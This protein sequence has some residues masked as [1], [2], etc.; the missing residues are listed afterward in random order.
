METDD[1]EDLDDDINNDNEDIDDEFFTDAEQKANPPIDL[2][3]GKPKGFYIVEQYAIPVD[4]FD[5]EIRSILDATM[6]AG[7]TAA[8][9]NG[10]PTSGVAGNNDVVDTGD[11]EDDGP[12][13]TIVGHG[14]TRDDLIRLNIDSGKNVTLPIAL[15][16]L[17]P[18]EYP[19]FSRARKACRKGYILIHEGPLEK[20]NVFDSDKCVRGRVRN[21]ILPEDVIGKQ[22]RMGG[23]FYPS[24][25]YQKPPFDL[26]VVYEDDHFAI[27]NK[28]PGVVVYSHRKGGHGTMTVRAALPFVLQPPKRGTHA[29]LRRPMACHRLDRPTAGLLLIAKT[30][31]AMVDV[32]RQF[33]SRNVKKTYMAIVNGIPDEPVETRLSTQEADGLGVDV[34]DYLDGDDSVSWQIIDYTLEEKSAVTVWRPLQYV[35]SLKARD[36]VLTLVEL[37]PKTGRYHQLRRHMA[38]VRDC[39]LVG[40]ST[41]DGGGDAMQLR[42]RGLFL[43]SN[44]VCLD[45]PYYNTKVG[46]EEWDTLPDAEKWAGGKIRLSDDGSTVEMHVSM[47]LP[48]KFDS[49][50]SREG[51]RETKFNSIEKE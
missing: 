13:T 19:S 6:V 15:M 37:K 30:K 5:A 16:L 34:L 3:E 32:T 47:D 28:P 8:A 31:P 40:D 38:W 35:K 12:E 1:E 33:V 48:D 46:R 4:G 18:V 7:G 23:G 41:Y 39:P 22:V 17:D 21:R 51:A 26:P 44:K 25:S 9:T 27:V 20:E 10:T 11:T 2:P 50:L 24:E 36:G 14:V 42:E 43:C 49:F 29:I 45:H